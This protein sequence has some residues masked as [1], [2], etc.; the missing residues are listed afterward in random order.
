M[1]VIVIAVY[2]PKAGKEEA[3][4]QLMQTH[5]PRLHKEGLVTDRPSIMMEA[6][7]HSVIEVF[8]WVSAEAIEQAHTNPAV[9]QMW[10]EYGELCDYIPL[11]DLAEAK[12]LFSS[13]QP[14]N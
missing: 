3:L 9:L 5:L 8:E 10:A 6:A 12:N 13:F 2:Q 7:D 1:G 4:R 14:L 11:A